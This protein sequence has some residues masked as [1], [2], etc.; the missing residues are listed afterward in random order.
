MLTNNTRITVFCSKKQGRETFWFATVLDGVNYHGRDQVIVADKN[1]SASDEYVIRIP[2]SVLQTTHYVDP[3]T[4]KS[5]PL[6]E[7]DNCYTLKKG[8]YVVKGLVDLDVITVKDILD[9]GGQ[10]ITQ[11]TENLSASAFSNHIKLVVKCF[12]NC[13]LILPKL[14]LKTVGLSRVARFKKLWTAKSFAVLLHMYLLKPAILSRA[15]F[16]AQR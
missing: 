11:V 2:N 12:L 6:D 5:L 3:S 7:S 14:C 1:L 13:F 16:V 15:V 8:D 9:A 10:Q 4:Y